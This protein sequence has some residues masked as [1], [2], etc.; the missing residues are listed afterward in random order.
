MNNEKIQ[1]STT[2]KGQGG[3]NIVGKLGQVWQLTKSDIEPPFCLNR[4]VDVDGQAV[5]PKL[6]RAW[7]SENCGGTES[8]GS[9]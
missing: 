4:Q 9:N 6:D 8:L 1:G 7:A 2:K 3:H 5:R